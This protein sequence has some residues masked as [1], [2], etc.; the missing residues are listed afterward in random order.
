[1]TAACTGALIPRQRIARSFGRAVRT[2]DQFAELQRQV[3]LRLLDMLGADRGKDAR[4]AQCILDAGCGTGFC[5]AALQAR[6]PGATVIALDLAEPMARATQH[7]VLDAVPLCADIQQLPLRAAQFD[8][9]LS[10][11]TIQW[12]SELRALFAELYRVTRIGGRVLLSTFGPAT[13]R[14]L[15]EAWASVD[16]RQHTSEFVAGHALLQAA[17]DAGFS[18]TLTP[19]LRIQHYPSLRVLAAELKGLGAHNLHPRQQAG[20]TSPGAFKA[21]SVAFAA[22]AQPGM[23]VPVSWEVFYLELKK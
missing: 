13:L 12:C 20:L 23:A 5:T 4:A 17:M 7:R 22:Q 15:R 3:A 2:Y 6:Y 16:T 11:L 9:V 1:M 10:S 21:A 18:A 19:E 14:E 8:V